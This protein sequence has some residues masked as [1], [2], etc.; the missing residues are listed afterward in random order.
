MYEILR[1]KA[2]HCWFC[3]EQLWQQLLLCENAVRW[4]SLKHAANRNQASSRAYRQCKQ[5]QGGCADR[6]A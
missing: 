2:G 1:M 5:W 3:L 6:L 4:A